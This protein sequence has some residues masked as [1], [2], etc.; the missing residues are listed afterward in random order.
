MKTLDS[1][2][3]EKGSRG[4][5]T[6]P[7]THKEPQVSAMVASLRAFPHHFLKDRAPRSFAAAGR[8]VCALDTSA[9]ARQ[10]GASLRVF[11]D[12]LS[13]AQRLGFGD[14]RR[15]RRDIL[16]NGPQS[17]D[18]VEALLALD[19]ALERADRGWPEYLVEAV[20]GFVISASD[21][22]GVVGPELAGWL[23]SVLSD[24]QPKTA[25]S[26]ARAVVSE[27]VEMDEALR[28]FAKVSAKRKPKVA[29]S[30][31]PPMSGSLSYSWHRPH[32]TSVL[33]QVHENDIDLTP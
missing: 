1:A 7:R 25:R 6:S 9:A 10:P 4:G 27:A 24:A 15:L 21:P 30:A 31:A 11:V 13:E 23:V 16:P 33:V 29:A 2:V 19:L 17:R 14:L 20:K 5:R 22:Q 18:D 3:S 8:S 12:R 26:I 28:A 32:L